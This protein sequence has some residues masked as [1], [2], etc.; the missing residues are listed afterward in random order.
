MTGDEPGAGG[1]SGRGSGYGL[2]AAFTPRGDALYVG[3]PRGRLHIYNMAPCSLTRTVT[4]GAASGCAVKAVVFAPKGDAFVVNST[5][6]TLRVYRVGDDAPL[7]KFQD[8]VNRVQWKTVC[9][10]NSG[11]FVVAGPSS[12]ATS[13]WAPCL[14]P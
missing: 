5:D 14:A 2:V 9:F 7:H 4:L 3:T 12:S 10:S 11:D 13:V 6:R 1:G 8:L